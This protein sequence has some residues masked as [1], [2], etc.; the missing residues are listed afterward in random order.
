MRRPPAKFARL[1]WDC[2]VTAE[3]ARRYKPAPEVYHTA[4]GLLGLP[5]A[6]VMLVAAHNYDLRA[7]RGEGLRTAFV[8]RP[9]EYGPGQTTDLAPESDW[10]VV[11]R[12]FVDLAGRLGA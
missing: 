6:Q 10:D 8:P 9:T 11:A 7:A 12:D 5:P 1:P 4:V 2:I 3:N